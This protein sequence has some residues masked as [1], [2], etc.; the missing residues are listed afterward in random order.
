MFGNS[1]CKDIE[2]SN[3]INCVMHAKLPAFP[4]TTKLFLKNEIRN[5]H[6]S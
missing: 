5:H 6:L 3:K 2:Q 4:V 1:C